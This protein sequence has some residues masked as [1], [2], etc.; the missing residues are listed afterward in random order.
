MS[1]EFQWPGRIV[2]GEQLTPG[3][4]RPTLPSNL[5]LTLMEADILAARLELTGVVL[6]IP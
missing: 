2:N 6:L 3:W 4:K 5:N 1:T